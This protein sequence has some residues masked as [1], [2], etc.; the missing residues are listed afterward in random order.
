[1]KMHPKQSFKLHN[2][3]YG[4]QILIIIPQEYLR[5]LKYCPWNLKSENNYRKTNRFSQVYLA[6]KTKFAIKNSINGSNS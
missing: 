1:M 4:M 2:Q 6:V 3:E 5:V